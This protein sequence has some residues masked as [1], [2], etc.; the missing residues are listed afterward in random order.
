MT[1]TRFLLATLVAATP[2]LAQSITTDLKQATPAGALATAG[3]ISDFKSSPANT[4]IGPSPWVWRLRASA[5]SG[6]GAT[7][8]SASSSMWAVR[9]TNNN[10][11]QMGMTGITRGTT[12]EKGL[13]TPSTS[14]TGKP[15]PISFL[16][17]LTGKPSAQ[18]AIRLTWQSLLKGT[19]T[20]FAS[21]D[22]GN[23]ST[24]EWKDG[25]V[26][27]GIKTANLPVAFDAKGKIVVKLSMDGT[28]TGAGQFVYSSLYGR[29]TAKFI[30]INAGKCTVTAYGSGCGGAAVA[31]GVLSVGNNHVL[32]LKMTGGYPNA[33]VVEAVGNQQTNLPLP[34]SCSLLCNAVVI[35]IHKTDAKG[36]YATTHKVSKYA[37]VNAYHQFLPV[38]LQGG[39]LV[40][41]TTNALRIVCTGR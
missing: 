37:A 3:T 40:I 17:T 18:G 13:F 27:G 31:A 22:V 24:V 29:L 23:D 11:V 38:D 6:S 41:R 9:N 32:S 36:E 8:L 10:G 28:T 2:V 39:Q 16:M 5:T 19:A 15:G 21:A 33:F 34:G 35:L 30:D 1:P 14:K 20:V 4:V 25:D 26:L 12:K 7:G